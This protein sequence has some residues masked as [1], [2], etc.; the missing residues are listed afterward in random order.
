MQET[1]NEK[2]LITFDNIR[3]VLW[4]SIRKTCF[5]YAL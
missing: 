3:S 2:M 5:S 4:N 1:I